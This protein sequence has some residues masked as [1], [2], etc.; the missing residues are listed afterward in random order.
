MAGPGLCGVVEQRFER[1]AVVV[2][3]AGD[4][5]PLVSNLVGSSHPATS[6]AERE[7]HICPCDAS[8]CMCRR[9]NAMVWRDRVSD[10]AS[11]LLSDSPT[12]FAY[13]SIC[14]HSPQQNGSSFLR[15]E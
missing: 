12:I 15:P 1:D 3:Q 11:R 8:C 2:E 13:S 14:V 4:E 6:S 7:Y 10:H 5:L 9:H